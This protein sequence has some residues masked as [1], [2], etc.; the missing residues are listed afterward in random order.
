M[1]RCVTPHLRLETVLDLDAA[2][3][4]SLGLDG[5]LL[6]LD[7]TLKDYRADSLPPDVSAWAASLRSDGVK[8]CLLSN[9]RPPKV[10]RFA[11]YL[12]I[13]YVAKAFKPLP[14]G[15]R[16]GVKVLGLEPS[17]AWAWWATSSSPTSSPAASPG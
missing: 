8:L 14:F 11:G 4:R 12:G 2:R 13:P 5:L 15:C 9:G 1:L 6:D 17:R 10:G 16:V 7:C 3:V